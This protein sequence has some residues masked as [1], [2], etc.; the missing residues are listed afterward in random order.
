[1]R[2]PPV[3]EGA[4]THAA[5]ADEGSSHCGVAEFRPRLRPVVPPRRQMPQRGRRR[6]AG[7]R[8]GIPAA[9]FDGMAPPG[10]VEVFHQRALRRVLQRR[11]QVE[12][13]PRHLFVAGVVF[14]AKEPGVVGIA[15]PCPARAARITGRL[16]IAAKT[17]HSGRHD[18]EQA[19]Q[20]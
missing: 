10:L 3:E 8:R 19:P 9:A 12:V 5:P 14:G 7:G 13:V 1:M 16:A 2:I 6:R 18:A 17:P 15:M 11:Q 4:P 20:S